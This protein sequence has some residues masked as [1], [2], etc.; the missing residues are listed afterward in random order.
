M[1]RLRF[2]CRSLSCRCTCS[3]IIYIIKPLGPL[4]YHQWSF[5][6]DK[7][8]FTYILILIIVFIINSINI[9]NTGG[10]NL[11]TYNQ[12]EEQLYRISD[13]AYILNLKSHVIRNWENELELDTPRST[14]GY[15]YYTKSELDK[16]ISIKKLKEHGF[17]LKQI[18]LLLPN[19]EALGKADDTTLTTLRKRM[20]STE[21]ANNSATP[22]AQNQPK[23][24][25]A[26][27]VAVMKDIITEAISDNIDAISREISSQ[28]SDSLT[29]EMNYQL[30]QHEN[31]INDR[32]KAF[33][34]KFSNGRAISGK[35]KIKKENH[36][37]LCSRFAK[38]VSSDCHLS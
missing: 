10:I 3:G 28:I 1:Y 32:L 38:R 35:P 6:V 31:I 30:I 8:S 13:A 22:S 19:L 16:L 9:L 20:N 17:S 37:G 34:G 25:S 4:I 27:F 36:F 15:R 26:E 5:F 11:N 18:K 7:I 21:I 14:S 29:K 24:S 33:E 23:I 12:S 2:M